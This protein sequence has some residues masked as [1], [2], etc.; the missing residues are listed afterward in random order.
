MYDS[1]VIRMKYSYGFTT[2]STLNVCNVFYDN[3]MK[4]K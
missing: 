1:K 4:Y 3:M 2:S